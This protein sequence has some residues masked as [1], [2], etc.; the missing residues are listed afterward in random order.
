VRSCEP[1]ELAF[2][3][4]ASI[5]VKQAAAVSRT[6]AFPSAMLVDEDNGVGRHLIMPMRRD[7][8]GLRQRATP[9]RFGSKRR[10]DAVA[11][12]QLADGPIWRACSGIVGTDLALYCED[13]AYDPVPR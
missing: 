2:A 4:M 10:W 12:A 3:G 9:C 6:L 1:K 5:T 7:R 8:I 11:A 13:W